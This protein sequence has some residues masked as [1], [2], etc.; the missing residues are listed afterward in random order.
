LQGIDVAVIGTGEEP[1]LTLIVVLAV[2]AVAEAVIIGVLW[3]QRAQQRDSE[4]RSMAI[5]R[6]APDLMVVQSRDG[7]YL[8]YY[9]RDQSRLYAPPDQFIGRNMRDVL[10]R[11]VVDRVAPLFA[12]V[13][14]SDQPV[15]IEYPIVMPEKTRHYEARLV[16]C[17]DDKVLSV[18][19]DITDRIQTEAAQ[20]Q[21]DE[22]LRQAQ[23]D[24]ERMS[25]LVALGEF[26][27]SIAHEVSQPLTATILNAKVCLKLL[28]D[29]R[30]DLAE[31][32]STVSEVV[33]ATNR[34]DAI[35]RRF[36]ELYRH[37]V[38]DKHPLHLHDVIG[39]VS[40]LAGPRLRSSGVQLETVVPNDL[41]ALV[42]D[43]IELC[44]LLLNLIANG[45]DAMQDS[46]VKSRAVT[47]TVTLPS[48]SEVEIAVRDTGVGLE[49]VDLSRMFATGYTTKAK[50]TGVGLSICRTIVEAHGGQI[51]GKT[52]AGPGATFTFRL[53]VDAGLKS[54]S[55]VPAPTLT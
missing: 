10:P 27:T 2:V 30:P 54:N 14:E 17:G 55:D 13:W 12:K 11:E 52:N 22:A 3:I 20:R 49:G 19:R 34:A 45:I 16:T 9:A 41:P 32:R 18:V 33:D 4:A 39:E 8:D 44:Q 21:S 31:I 35:I 43:Q 29:E 26:A 5:L 37:R 23:A 47:I 24:L 53:P 1:M 42:G 28:G 38:V 6:A 25:R 46:D 50:G 36:R 51:W 7:V 15:I 48:E 40:R